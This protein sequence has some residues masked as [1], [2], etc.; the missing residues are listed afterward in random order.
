MNLPPATLHIILR[1]SVRRPYFPSHSFLSKPLR[2]PDSTRTNAL[3]SSPS[4]HTA[5]P[6]SASA[7]PES[8][9]HNA[10]T[11]SQ[12]QNRVLSTLLVPIR[13]YGRLQQRRPYLTQIV[14][15]VSIWTAGDILAQYITSKGQNSPFLA[16]YDPFKTMRAMI[17]GGAITLPIYY[18]FNFLSTSRFSIA[19]PSSLL[20]LLTRGTTNADGVARIQRT[21]NFVL[22]LGNRIVV[23]QLTFTPVFLTYFFTSHAV[24]APLI[25]RSPDPSALP[26]AGELGG[27]LAET[28]SRGF[29]NSWKLWPAVTAFQFTLV[30]PQYRVSVGWIATFG[31][32][33]YLGWLNMRTAREKEEKKGTIEGNMT[34]EVAPLKRIQEGEDRTAAQ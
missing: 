16:S 1:R 28:V 26:S 3:N 8:S 15:S 23:N 33:T 13:A 6:K 24:L 21:A 18:W 30:Q 5:K 14:T 20:S 9:T 10:S 12:P 11:S 31:W 4:E 2:R 27:K 32:Q 19:L 25:T 17:I 29:V 7:A 34:Q 22:S